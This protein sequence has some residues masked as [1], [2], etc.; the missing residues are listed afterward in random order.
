MNYTFQ[1]TNNETLRDTDLPFAPE[2]KVNVV[3]DYR[4]LSELSVYWHTRWLDRQ[5]ASAGNEDPIPSYVDHNLNLVYRLT[6]EIEASLGI[7]NVTDDSH[8]EQTGVP[9]EGRTFLASV[10]YRFR[11][12]PSLPDLQPS[13]PVEP[14]GLARA[15]AAVEQARA[16]GAEDLGSRAYKEAVAHLAI[17]EELYRQGEEEARVLGAAELARGSAESALEEI[18]RRPTPAPT[19]WAPAIPPA[20]PTTKPVTPAPKRTPSAD[21]TPRAEGAPPADEVTPA[22]EPTEAPPT[23]LPTATPTLTPAATPTPTIDVRSSRVL[24]LQSDGMVGIYRETATALAGSLRARV[25]LHDLQGDRNRGTA[26]LASESADAALVVAVG[27][28][29]ATLARESVTDRPV[30]FCGVLN[31]ERYDL[32][33]PNVAGVRFEISA[34]TQLRRMSRALPAARSIGVLYD[35]AKSETFVAEAERAAAAIGLQLVKAVVR[36]PRDV[37]F[38]FRSIRSDVDVLWL[39]PDSTVV[40]R[41]SF[42]VLALQTAEAKIPLV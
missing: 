37:A 4:P 24:L 18:L 13:T 21:G 33:A 23:P 42:E 22:I 8:H 2:N 20:P 30:L 6:R 36:D 38:V 10:A 15:R 7:Y 35:P 1:D 31:P 32:S 16:A 9:R 3:F 26:I 29:A 14:T 19:A 17:A 41:E 12:G 28:L 27:S 39:I 25:E 5:F 40:T 11:P 34:A